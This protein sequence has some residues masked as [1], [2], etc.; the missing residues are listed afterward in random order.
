[1]ASGG[2]GVSSTRSTSVSFTDLMGAQAVQLVD[3]CSRL[4]H[5]LAPLVL[6]WLPSV[7]L[8]ASSAAASLLIALLH[9]VLLL[10]CCMVAT[11][12]E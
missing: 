2:R 11:H 5:S 6:L 9:L 1:M 7:P 12:A 10:L 3:R 4:H 8:S